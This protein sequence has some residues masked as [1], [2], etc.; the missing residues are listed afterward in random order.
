VPKA[1]PLT[2]LERRDTWRIYWTAFF[3]RFALG[4]TIW[5]VLRN[6]YALLLQDAAYYERMGA[7]VAQDWL[8]GRSSLWLESAISSGQQAGQQAWLMVAVIAVFYYLMGGI[9]A[10]PLLIGAFAA[11]TAFTPVLTYRIAR[12]L[13]ASVTE[14]RLAAGLVMFSPA[15]VFW[16][17]ALYKE[18]LILL[19]LNV[20]ILHTLRLL[21]GWKTSSFVLIAVSIPLIFGLR[22]Y[23]AILLALALAVCLLLGRRASHRVG[24]HTVLWLKQG[25]I[26]AAF[27][28]GLLSLGVIHRMTQ[29]FQQQPKSLLSV[30]EASRVDLA[31]ARSGYLRDSDVSTVD[32]AMVHLPK[33]AAYFL[34]SPFPWQPGSGIQRLTKPETAFWVVLYPFMIAGA[35]VLRKKHWQGVVLIL[36]LTLMLTTFYSLY[37][38]NVGTAYRMRTQVWLFWSIFAGAGI[39]AFRAWLRP[40]K[41]R[42][43]ALDLERLPVPA[44]SAAAFRLNRVSQQS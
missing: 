5:F 6:N 12:I 14:S 27:V 37:V 13:H 11:L 3:I 41:E 9:R 8:N 40:R 30:V 39:G 43:V 29:L 24:G 15:F 28:A 18:G 42:V 25:I 31:R 10:V 20:S 26:A 32:K 19:L 4:C 16:S 36:V 22:F 17:G 35:F 38:G 33:G 44:V 23:V 34:A 21:D 2:E 7:A 1:A